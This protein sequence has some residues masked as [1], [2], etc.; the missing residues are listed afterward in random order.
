MRWGICFWLLF[1]LPTKTSQIGKGQDLVAPSVGSPGARETL[2]F[3][4]W[5]LPWTDKGIPATLGPVASLHNAGVSVSVSGMLPYHQA[6][7]GILA[8]PAPA[9]GIW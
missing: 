9:A 4:R 1:L 6:H 3:G 8:V 5:G 2:H 7:H